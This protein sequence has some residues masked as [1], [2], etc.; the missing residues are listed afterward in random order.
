ML[1][2]LTDVALS[3]LKAVLHVVSLHVK[4]AYLNAVALL[5]LP[6]LLWQYTA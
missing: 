3:C 5:G 2:H 4:F 6:C 1:L